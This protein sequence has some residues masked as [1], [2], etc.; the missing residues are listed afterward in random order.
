MLNVILSFDYELFFGINYD[1]ADSIL[2]EPTDKIMDVL[3]KH[4]VK[5]AFFVD[6]LSYDK[7]LTVDK[8]YSDKL[9]NQCVNMFERGHE[10]HLHVHAHWLSANY[11]NNSKNWVSDYKKYK[12]QAYQPEIINKTIDDGVNLLNE[13]AKSAHKK[14][15]NT[16]FRAGGLTLQP[17]KELINLLIKKGF[18]YDSSVARYTY[19]NIVGAEYNFKKIPSK[20][21][22]KIS[23][24]YGVNK[25]AEGESETLL[26]IP[27]ATVKNNPFRILAQKKPARIAN[28]KPGGKGFFRPVKKPNKLQKITRKLFDYH[29]VSLDTRSA[30][31][32]MSDLKVIYKKYKCKRNDY[33]IA[34]IGHPKMFSQKNVDNLSTLIG[35]L[36]Q[37]SD[38]FNVISFSDL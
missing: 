27:V 36:K 34:L 25:D 38:K 3:D 12:L 14:Y 20:L 18:K 24:K 11:D 22:W 13:C 35:L 31:L 26:E 28:S 17:E 10:P 1:S 2:F 37:Q 5:G 21:N 7:Y 32:I 19:S 29:W 16:A 30:Q 23:S 8:S 6:T 9:F 15:N 33:T 4:N